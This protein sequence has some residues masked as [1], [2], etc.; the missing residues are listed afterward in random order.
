MS[1]VK[2]FEK[3][4][5]NSNYNNIQIPQKSQ[6][7]LSKKRRYE[8]GLSK[9]APIE[10]FSKIEGAD[11]DNYISTC[12][13]YTY[14]HNINPVD[15]R[16][17]KPTYIPLSDQ[18]SIREASV[19][20]E[21]E[22]EDKPPKENPVDTP[23]KSYNSAQS[24]TNIERDIS[25]NQTKDN[26]SPNLA[27]A[28]AEK[29]SNI[30]KNENNKNI[31]SFAF[32]NHYFNQ[33][34]QNIIYQYFG[35]IYPF[36][37]FTYLMI[38][39]GE[40]GPNNP[41][42]H[43]R[44][45]RLPPSPPMPF[46]PQYNIIQS[47]DKIPKTINLPVYYSLAP[48]NQ[49]PLILGEG[50]VP[51]K[52]A[53]FRQNSPAPKKESKKDI[54][55]LKDII[56]DPVSN[57][58]TQNGSLRIQIYYEIGS[59]EVRNKI[60]EKLKPEIF[61]LSKH[62]YGNYAI[63]KIFGEKVQEKHSIL[64]EAIKDNIIELSL[65]ESGS[66]VIQE[67]IEVIDDK[68]LKLIFSEIQDKISEF[69]EDKNGN[70]VIQ[71]LIERLKEEEFYKIFVIVYENLIKF[72]KEQYGCYIIKSLLKKCNKQLLDIIL[73]KIFENSI[74]LINNEYGNYIISFIFENL[75]AADSENYI[76]ENIKKNIIE[77]GRNKHAVHVIEKV[78]NFGSQ[79]QKRSIIE[80]I[81]SLD[82]KTKNIFLILAKDKYGNYLVQK[83]LKT[84]DEKNRKIIIDKILSNK[85]IF[86]NDPYA[87]YVLKKIEEL[88][89]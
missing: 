43:Y 44:D 81:I 15:P 75:I 18:N 64:M 79:E 16:L 3:M 49:A 61:N 47:E 89:K 55:N 57:A 50:S 4:D 24:Q 62:R 48:Y 39:N 80:E 58:K 41:N 36:Y 52:Q 20:N 26:S 6:N 54:I 72:A 8:P 22:E 68:N 70:H 45:P 63:Q 35:G 27:K 77:W 60:F 5:E 66:R 69:I 71:I 10:E 2:N 17:P 78:L 19:N 73:K 37:P 84:C 83:L 28:G 42:Y 51:Q 7:E 33:N 12:K 56:Q 40:M 76:L 13:Y 29:E 23:L 11:C 30:S 74:E 82:D 1:Q 46:F 86:K 38:N 85:I 53:E 21:E 25:N 34:N 9:T 67:L 87:K 88:K 14:Y 31:P 59:E 65:D 32:Q